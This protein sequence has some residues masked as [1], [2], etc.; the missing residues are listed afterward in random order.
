MVCL[1][2]DTRLWTVAGCSFA[3]INRCRVA[4]E[5]LERFKRVA[6]EKAKG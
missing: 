3:A 1:T 4:A 6:G 5:L 2:S